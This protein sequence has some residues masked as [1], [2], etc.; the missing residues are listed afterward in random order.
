MREIT[1]RNNL[2]GKKEFLQ[3]LTPGQIKMYACGVTTYDDCHIGHAMQA[4]FFDVIRHY[5]EFI[6]YQVTYVRNYTDVDDKIIKRASELGLSPVDLSAKI[7]ASSEQDMD[8]IGVAKANHEP[9]VSEMIPE[10][11]SMV[12]TLIDKG[13]AYCTRGGDV[14]FRVRDK[15]DYGKLSNRNPEELRSGTRA[16]VQG[17]KEDELD[18]ALWKSDITPGASWN[19]PWGKGRP[20]WHI[21]CSAMSQHFLGDSFDIHGGGRDLIFPHHENE[22]AQSECATGKPYAKVWMHCGLLTIEKQKMSKSLG[23]HISIKQFLKS[24]PGEVLRLSYLSHHYSSDIDFS[25]KLFEL[26]R[27]RLLYYYETLQELQDA[28]QGQSKT[29]LTTPAKVD[30]LPGYNPDELLE[31]FHKAMCDDFNTGLAI[32]AVNNAMRKARSILALKKS[33]QSANIAAAFF[34]SFQEIGKVF[35]IMI[36]EPSIFIRQLTDLVLPELGLTRESIDKKL[37]ERAQARAEK[38]WS[39]SDRI[40]DELLSL[41]VLIRDGVSGTTWSIAPL[42]ENA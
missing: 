32:A 36:M 8:Q 37:A 13:M 11:I 28:S 31:D 40:R 12:Q 23:N 27:R 35:G 22:I 42:Q 10:I 19:S 18:F 16:I 25:Q 34:K 7:I 33:Q 41:G 6:G 14:Y 39:E 15:Q 3:P 26:N 17:D 29:I 21:E 30:F 38:N 24:W 2:T 5:L 20:G 4:I 1:I 9:K